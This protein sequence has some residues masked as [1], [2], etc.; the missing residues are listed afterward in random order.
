LATRSPTQT[1]SLPPA[2]VTFLGL[3]T[4]F[5]GY[6]AVYA[7]NDLIDCRVDRETLATGAGP[8]ATRDLDS[9][10]IRH[11]LAQDLLSRR[12]ALLWTAAWAGVAMVGATL[13]NPV[14]PVIFLLASL[15]EIVYCRLLRK[16]WLRIVISGIVKTSGPVAA[17]LAVTP[18]PPLPF[19]TILALWLFFWEIGGQ[20]APND[21]F[22][23]HSDRQIGARS[24]AVRFGPRVTIRIIAGTLATTVA[25]SL[26]LSFIAPV[27]LG[28]VYPA[29]ALISGFYFLLLPC[30]H[31]WHSGKSDAALALFN[32]ACGYPLSMLLVTILSWTR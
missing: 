27:S 19:L 28:W 20:N 32:R 1:P 25:M 2:G 9:V 31:L 26:A 18:T 7:L 6:S 3:L 4:A 13:L 21:L 15:L 29:G 17:V 8:A 5:A 12:A 10:F 11:P 22:D 23:L 16:T 14:C 30:Y 24:L